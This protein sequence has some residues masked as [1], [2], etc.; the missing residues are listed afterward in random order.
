MASNDMRTCF[1]VGC[2]C[3]IRRLEN[4]VGRLCGY[5]TRWFARQ[6]R[7][8]ARNRRLC[9]CFEARRLSRRVPCHR[10]GSAGLRTRLSARD[11]RASRTQT[12]QALFPGGRGALCGRGT[13]S[14]AGRQTGGTRVRLAGRGGSRLVA[15]REHIS[16]RIFYCRDV[17]ET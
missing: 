8:A 13:S 3:S 2:F 17:R 11:R 10:R 1:V 9:L 16:A 4:I 5:E 14:D 12:L 6:R 15:F 7:G